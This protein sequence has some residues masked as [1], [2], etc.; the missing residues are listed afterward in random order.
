MS[1]IPAASTSCKI[2]ILCELRDGLTVDHVVHVPRYPKESAV[3][4]TARARD[5]FYQQYPDYSQF[6]VV[7]YD[8]Y[9]GSR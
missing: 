2:R 5:K 9:Y 1:S 3:T 8:L 7:A 4:L 6:R